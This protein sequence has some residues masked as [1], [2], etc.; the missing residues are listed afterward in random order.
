MPKWNG[1]AVNQ[2]GGLEKNDRTWLDTYYHRFSTCVRSITAN[3]LRDNIAYTELASIVCSVSALDL[4]VF[5]R[6]KVGVFRRFIKGMVEAFVMLLFFGLP[7]VLVFGLM[8][9]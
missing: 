4:L 2:V 5:H 7:E 3:L 1:L 9:L 8:R 6:E